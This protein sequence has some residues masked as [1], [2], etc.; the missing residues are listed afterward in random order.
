[1]EMK[2]RLSEEFR[3]RTKKFASVVVRLFV[4]LPKNREEVRVIGKQ[5]L[6]SGTSVAGHAREASRAR[7]DDEFVSKLGGALQE[8]DESALWLELLRE[9]CGI[10]PA[11]TLPIE[12]EADEL[13]AI[14]TTMINRTKGKS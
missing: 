9:D 14:M 2:G 3:N 1:M 7:S 12:K 8:A 13:M 11:H 5:L 4:E 6:R 10:S